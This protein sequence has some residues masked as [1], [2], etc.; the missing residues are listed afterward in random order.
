VMAYRLE[1]NRING[2]RL[3]EWDIYRLEA[4]SSGQLGYVR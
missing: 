4:N 2:S 1:E 3:T